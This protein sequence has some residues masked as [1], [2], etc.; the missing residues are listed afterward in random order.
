MSVGEGGQGLNPCLF[1]DA[2]HRSVW[3]LLA[4][5]PSYRKGLSGDGAVPN[6]MVPSASNNVTSCCDEQLSQFRCFH[7]SKNFYFYSANI[8]FL[9]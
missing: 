6:V 3:N 7:K 9:I 5:V 2:V 1:P 4:F 8:S